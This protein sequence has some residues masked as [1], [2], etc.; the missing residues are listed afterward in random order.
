MVIAD[1]S[2]PHSNSQNEVVVLKAPAK[3]IAGLPEGLS[4]LLKK[5]IDSASISP[6]LRSSYAAIGIRK[7]KVVKLP[8]CGVITHLLIYI[9]NGTEVFDI[10]M[11]MDRTRYV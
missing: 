8:I 5:I 6:R 2:S 7:R 3:R 4:S 9:M 1:S 10:Q 11:V